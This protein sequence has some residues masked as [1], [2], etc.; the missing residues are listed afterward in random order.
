MS[1]FILSLLLIALIALGML[2][3]VRPNYEAFK[4]S[5][6]GEGHGKL[7]PIDYP[8][9]SQC[10]Q[11]PNMRGCLAYCLQQPNDPICFRPDPNFGCLFDPMFRGCPKYCEQNAA[12]AIC[13]IP[14]T[15]GPGGG[16]QLG[17]GGQNQ[18]PNSNGF[19]PYLPPALGPGGQQNPTL[20]P[21]GQNQYPNMYGPGGQNQYP[22]MYGP[23]GQDQ[24]PNMYGPGGQDQYPSGY[25][26]WTPDAPNPDPYGPPSGY[27]RDRYRR[28]DHW[29]R[30][31]HHSNDSCGSD[32][33]DCDQ[34]CEDN[35]YIKMDEVPCYNCTLP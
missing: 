25:G 23:G 1:T 19:N 17:P 6:S 5:G 4:G 8:T 34:S 33:S 16:K 20:G 26:P 22:N 13:M 27:R 10:A 28:E 14:P 3:A 15:L 11:D 2:M 9:V 7:K 31:S 30:S 18:N 12:D 32:K 21:G 24:Y 35:G 29:K